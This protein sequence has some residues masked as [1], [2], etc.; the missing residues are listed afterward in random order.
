MDGKIKAGEPMMAK[1]RLDE[2]WQI[3][4]PTD[5]QRMAKSRLE[6]K[7]KENES[8]FLEPLTRACE[9]SLK[10]IDFQC[11]PKQTMAFFLLNCHDCFKN[12]VSILWWPCVTWTK[13]K[14]GG[15]IDVVHV[16]VVAQG[17]FNS[18]ILQYAFSIG[19]HHVSGRHVYLFHCI[20]FLF[21]MG[22]QVLF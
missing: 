18:L 8:Q 2:G 10:V 4:G 20:F 19:L 3:Q 1:S 21:S 6:R 11:F 17:L 16:C 22:S 9:F 12:I 15:D 14:H 5:E 13:S 7:P